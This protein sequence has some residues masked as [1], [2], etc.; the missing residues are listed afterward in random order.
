MLIGVIGLL[1]RNYFGKR[2]IEWSIRLPH[3]AAEQNLRRDQGQRRFHRAAKLR[4]PSSGGVP[5]AGI[6]HRLYHE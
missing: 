6:F 2:I 3:S 4:A 5:R 1:A